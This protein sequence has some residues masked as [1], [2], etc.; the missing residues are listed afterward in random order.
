M[1]YSLKEHAYEGI[2]ELCF[3]VL[4]DIQQDG[5]ILEQCFIVLKNIHMENPRAMHYC[6][7]GYSTRWRNNPRAMLYCLKEH[8]YGGIL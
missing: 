2:L 1:L 6:H 5:G 7:K 4:K 3:I 8:A